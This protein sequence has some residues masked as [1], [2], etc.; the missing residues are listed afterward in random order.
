MVTLKVAGAGLSPVCMFPSGRGFLLP[1]RPPE[2]APLVEG[3][4]VDAQ[5]LGYLL[6]TLVVGQS[7]PPADISLKSWL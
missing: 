1:L 2:L 7:H 6:H 3:H 5:S 4:N